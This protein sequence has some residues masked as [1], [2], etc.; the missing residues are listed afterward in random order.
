MRRPDPRSAAVALLVAGCCLSAGYGVTGC[1]TAS[2]DRP[3]APTRPN[4][5]TP[6]ENPRPGDFNGDGYDD[7]TTV[8]TSQSKDRSRSEENLVVVYGSRDGLAPATA[9]RTSPG[10][11][12]AYFTSPCAP[13]STATATPTWSSAAAGATPV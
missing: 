9:Q 3:A 13:T 7:F 6:T 12:Y 4:A 2:P 5:G 11:K 8:L 10:K 1:G